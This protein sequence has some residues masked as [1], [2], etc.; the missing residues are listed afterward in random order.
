MN[1]IYFICQNIVTGE[2]SI[3]L[4]NYDHSIY[5]MIDKFSSY[6][7]ANYYFYAFLK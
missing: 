5:H 4:N 1:N 6:T 2:Y 3:Q 7:E